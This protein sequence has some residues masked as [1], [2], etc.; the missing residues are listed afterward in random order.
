MMARCRAVA[1][2]VAVLEPSR[3]VVSDE[4]FEKVAALIEDPPA[5]TEALRK[6]MRGSSS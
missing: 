4:A 5:P 1:G 6:L 2:A 3:L